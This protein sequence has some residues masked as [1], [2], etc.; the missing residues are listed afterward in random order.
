MG[1]PLF[2]FGGRMATAK[3]SGGTSVVAA[4]RGRGKTTIPQPEKPLRPAQCRPF[5]RKHLAEAFPKIVQGFVNEAEKGS[6]THVKLA[7][8]LLE[9][10]RKATTNWSRKNS[11]REVMQG[12]ER[13]SKG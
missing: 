6:C 4:K 2:S 5:M 12:W 7:T 1:P 8:E 10:K 3:K 11:V 9:P 13:R